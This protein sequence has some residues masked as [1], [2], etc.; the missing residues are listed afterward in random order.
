MR[1]REFKKEIR[2]L[3]IDDAPFDKFKDKRTLL[4][5][6]F[7][8]GGSSLDGVLSTYVKVDGRDSTGEIAKLVERSKFKTQIRA[9]L[10]DGI[11]VGGFNIVDIEKLNKKTKIPVI[12]VMRKKP[13]IE[14][15]EKALKKLGMEKKIILLKKAG[16]IHQADNIFI[17]IEGITL[18]KARK[19]IKISTSRSFIPEPIRT[20]HLIAAGIVL[21]ESKGRA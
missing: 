9:I 1:K 5:G 20:A 2:L 13:N 6:T 16:E 8:R 12:V 21:G 4:I 14:K 15:I 3:G 10:L 11:A 19:I 7:F 18:E 17:Q